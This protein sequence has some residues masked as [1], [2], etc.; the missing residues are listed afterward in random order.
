M[1]V[2]VGEGRVCEVIG[3]KSPKISVY[4]QGYS[5]LGDDIAYYY[6]IALSNT[7]KLEESTTCC[8]NGGSCAKICNK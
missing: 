1:C 6:V 2:C 4:T 8:L 5:I 7:F 3:C